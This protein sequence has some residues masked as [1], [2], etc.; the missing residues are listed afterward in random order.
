MKIF[1]KTTSDPQAWEQALYFIINTHKGEIFETLGCN[2]PFY[3]RQPILSCD[4][5]NSLEKA[6]SEYINKRANVV[7]AV[8][9]LIEIGACDAIPK[10]YT[11]NGGWGEFHY[12][13]FEIDTDKLEFPTLHIPLEKSNIFIKY[14]KCKNFPIEIAKS[15]RIR[16]ED[17]YEAWAFGNEFNGGTGYTYKGSAPSFELE[18]G[19]TLKHYSAGHIDGWGSGFKGG[20]YI[21]KN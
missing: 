21:E 2:H 11:H 12:L 6:I 13:V 20:S 3:Y 8:K 16:P 10:K 1:I 14:G 5:K 7:K 4:V 17:W 19:Y 15:E 18:E 9:A